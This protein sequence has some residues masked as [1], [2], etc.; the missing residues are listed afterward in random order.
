[1]PPTPNP[2]PNLGDPLPTG[3]SAAS[4]WLAAS[5]LLHA[6]ILSA[7][8]VT[9]TPKLTPI[10]LPGDRAGHLQMLAYAPHGGTPPSALQAATPTPK[11]PTAT[12]TLALPKPAA[13][14]ATAPSATPGKDTTA[15]ADA[16]GDGNMT[17][18][19]VLDHPSP[20]PDL[21]TLPSG[22]HGDVIIDVVIDQTGHIAKFNLEHGL[23]HGIDETVLATIQQWTFHPATRNGQPIAS[24]QELLF[25]YERG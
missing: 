10:H 24:E 6:T 25:H 18:A 15:G 20:H 16:L 14:P 17:I 12:P 22:T 5:L 3:R 4:R 2:L 21:S 8:L 11:P 19:L 23:G 1:M 9:R 13:A 7:F